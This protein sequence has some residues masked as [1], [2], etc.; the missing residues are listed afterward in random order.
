V[1]S[2]KNLSRGT[3]RKGW[4]REG[5]RGNGVSEYLGKLGLEDVDFIEEK[6]DRGA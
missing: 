3:W 1:Y 5:G 4:S 2:G 6:D